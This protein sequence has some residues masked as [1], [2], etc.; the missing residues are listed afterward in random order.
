MQERK[1]EDL[2]RKLAE[3][4]SEIKAIDD[5]SDGQRDGNKWIRLTL[6]PLI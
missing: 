3:Y 5:E 2:D 4:E 6:L 1:D